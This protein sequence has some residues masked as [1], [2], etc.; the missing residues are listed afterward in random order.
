MK[1]EAMPLRR[2]RKA[3]LLKSQHLWSCQISENI[4]A[5]QHGENNIDKPPILAEELLIALG[6]KSVFCRSVDKKLERDLRECMWDLGGD[7]RSGQ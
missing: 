5:S 3:I 1:G 2:Y 7:E 4:Q 6:K